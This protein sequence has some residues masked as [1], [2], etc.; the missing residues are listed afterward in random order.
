MPK[1]SARKIVKSFV[2]K[3]KRDG[4]PFERVYLFGSCA[5]GLDKKWS[6][7]DV[8]VVSDK[9]AGKRW[10]SYEKR[11]WRL[12]REI[13]SRIEP[14]GMTNEEFNGLSPLSEEVKKT[15]IRVV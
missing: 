5:K 1:N 14:I 11:L 2:L 13:D 12:R 4:F 7:I 3:M 10:D 8:C 6:D 15:G 9:F